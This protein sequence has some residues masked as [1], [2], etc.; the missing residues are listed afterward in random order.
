MDNLGFVSYAGIVAICYLIGAIINVSNINSRYI[1]PIMGVCGGLLGV[2]CFFIIPNFS[3]NFI[4]AIATGI[5]SGFAATGINQIHKQ[6][7]GNKDE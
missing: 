1:P 4:N 2:G 6:L 3:D 5:V 7:G